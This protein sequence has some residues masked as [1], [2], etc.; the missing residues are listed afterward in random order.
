MIMQ[1]HADMA[2]K[3]IDPSLVPWSDVLDRKLSGKAWKP[4]GMF[5]SVLHTDSLYK[6]TLT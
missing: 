6:Q 4:S 5:V 2:N 1:N 3:T